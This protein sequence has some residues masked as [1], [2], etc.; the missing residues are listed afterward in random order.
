[1]DWHQA[2]A[3]Y[4]DHARLLVE[5][6][7]WQERT[8]AMAGALEIKGLSA[9]VEAARAAIRKARAAVDAMNTAGT[10][11]VTTANQVA[12]AFTK[13]EEDILFEAQTLGNSPS[14]SVGSGEQPKSPPAVTSAVPATPPPVPPVHTTVDGVRPRVGA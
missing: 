6:D 9:N 8:M 4:I 3:L 5:R 11:L 14:P 12:A 13:A 10:S 7:R 2:I 1:M